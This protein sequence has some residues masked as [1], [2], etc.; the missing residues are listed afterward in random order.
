MIRRGVPDITSV[1]G[2]QYL[3]D[4]FGGYRAVWVPTNDQFGE[5]L[6][7]G[8]PT[9]THLLA[10]NPATLKTRYA[11][12]T[13]TLQA[14]PPEL[15]QSTSQVAQDYAAMETFIDAFIA[16]LAETVSVGGYQLAGGAYVNDKA[17]HVRRGIDYQ[18]AVIVAL[19]VLDI[20]W[21][22]AAT[23]TECAETYIEVP[24]TAEVT[25][26]EQIVP[27]DY[28]AA[29]TYTAPTEE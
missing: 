20:Q 8:P 24:A 12:A 25:V 9:R 14:R 7:S 17:R 15:E 16:S 21:P 13:V 6:P 3:A 23:T 22:I 5:K 10:L 27:P 11:A 18:L 2:E 4:H 26:E 19:P 28:E 29:I 1:Y